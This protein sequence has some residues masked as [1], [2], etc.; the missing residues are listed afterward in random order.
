MLTNL[1]KATDNGFPELAQQIKDSK[2][3]GIAKQL[4]NSIQDELNVNW[5]S[6]KEAIMVEII[7]AKADQVQAFRKQLIDSGDAIIAEAT[8]DKF[9][10]CGLNISNTT[11]TK[12]EYLPG[13]NKLRNILMNTRDN[14]LIE[15]A[16]KEILN[17]DGRETDDVEHT[18]TTLEQ[19]ETV[20]DLPVDTTKIDMIRMTVPNGWSI[21]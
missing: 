16:N 3:A 20:Q 9:W 17:S 11:T 18:F 6:A 10:A 13:Q 4:S 8:S 2:H 19:S 15:N 21:K 14:Y 7:K 5:E 1:K 12:R